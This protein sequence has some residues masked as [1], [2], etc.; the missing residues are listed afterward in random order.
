MLVVVQGWL[1][2][3][4]SRHGRLLAVAALAILIASQ[5]AYATYFAFFPQLMR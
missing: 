5:F 3:T 1:P 2:P 4:I